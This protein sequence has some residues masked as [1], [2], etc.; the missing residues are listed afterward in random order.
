MG[1]ACE[2]QATSTACCAVAQCW[3]RLRGRWQLF[4]EHPRAVGLVGSSAA[5]PAPAWR[6][7][8]AWR[9]T[10]AERCELG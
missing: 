8:G 5:D 9:R 7:S 10:R 2:L 6:G 4:A 1:L 3:G